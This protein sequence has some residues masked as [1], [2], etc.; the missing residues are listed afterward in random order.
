[1][2]KQ[3]SC[4]YQNAINQ[5]LFFD[6]IRK[7]Q[8]YRLQYAIKRFA[9]CKDLK[10]NSLFLT[11]FSHFEPKSQLAQPLQNQIY[12]NATRMTVLKLSA[13]EMR[14]Q[15]NKWRPYLICQMIERILGL[16]YETKI[17]QRDYDRFLVIGLRHYA[18]PCQ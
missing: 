11:I 10:K 16:I 4:Q 17:Y 5:P 7:L 12:E 15:N 1:M 9:N 6:F 8:N 18:A 2:I 3:C 13:F 14:R